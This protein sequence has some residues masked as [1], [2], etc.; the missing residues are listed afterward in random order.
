VGCTYNPFLFLLL[1]L[2]G[3]L[4]ELMCDQTRIFNNK[5]LWPEDGS[6]PF[7]WSNGDRYVILLFSSHLYPRFRFLLTQFR[8]PY[9][10]IMLMYASTGFSQHGDYV[11]GWKGDALQRAMNAHC[12]GDK[13]NVLDLQSTEDAVK[14]TVPRTVEEG[15]DG[16]K[17]F[18]TF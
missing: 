2:E 13:C 10:F 15:V 11:F 17:L 6:Q 1:V 18:S 16:C 3:D 9:A 14:C 12:T 5:D 7:V 8:C 4:G